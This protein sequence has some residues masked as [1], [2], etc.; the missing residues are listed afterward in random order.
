MNTELGKIKKIKLFS[1]LRNIR[2]ELQEK[3]QLLD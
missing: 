2:S 3:S 1:E